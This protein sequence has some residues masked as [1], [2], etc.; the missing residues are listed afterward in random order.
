MDS[1]TSPSATTTDGSAQ[2][3]AAAALARRSARSD[4]I[5]VIADNDA[6][7]L[8]VVLAALRTGRIP[9]LLNPRLTPGELDE[10]TADADP[11][12]V[13]TDESHAARAAGRP[14]STLAELTAGDGTEPSLS[15]WPLGRPMHYTSGT[16]GRSKGV[17]SGVL[18]EQAGRLLCEEERA[19]W[20]F[21]PTDVHLVCSSVSHS[22]PAR[23]ALNTLVYGGRVIVL[24]S[25]D[26]SQFLELIEQQRVTTTFTT[27]THLARLIDDPGFEQRDL[28]SLRLLAHAGAPCPQTVKRRITERLPGIVWEFYGS[29]EGQFTALAP[30]EWEQRPWSVGRARPGRELRVVED[31][32]VLAPGGVGTIWSTCPPPA[33]FTYWRDPAKTDAT[34][35]DRIGGEPGPWFSVGDLGSM[36]EDGYVQLV[37]R[38]TDLIITGGVNVYPAQVERVLN[39]CPGVAEGVVF[40]VPDPAWGQRVCAAVVAAPDASLEPEQVRRWLRERLAGF[41]TPKD[42]RILNDPLPRTASGKL[43]RRRL[44]DQFDSGGVSD[45]DP[46][47][48]D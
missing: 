38:R 45:P 47:S 43:L 32:R 39:T 6:R 28:S 16:T 20:G 44:A 23:F 29:T 22:A 40:G 14:A 3:P 17:Y 33:Q 42:V 48:E 24:P 11:A 36:D 19:L 27:P 12:L 9:V 25:F 13:V 8:D 4:R 2:A 10:L 15:P 31:G 21:E 34:W 30:E 7:I 46:R 5:V 35:Q 37:G 41:Q 26:T 18:S 1:A